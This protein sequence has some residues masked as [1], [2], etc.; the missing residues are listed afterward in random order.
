VV[1]PALDLSWGG[2]VLT[3]INNLGIDTV[4]LCSCCL[5]KQRNTSPDGTVFISV[6]LLSNATLHENV[7]FSISHLHFRSC[8]FLLNC[9]R[10]AVKHAL[11][12]LKMIATSGFLTALECT[13]FDF[14]RGSAPYPA[15]ELTLEALR[16]A[17][18]KFS[19]YLLTYSAPPAD[20]VAGLRGPASKER[21][22]RGT[23][24]KGGE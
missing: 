7:T 9:D 12:I 17:L 10:S 13:E 2:G 18:Y 16:N 6:L 3:L 5:V 11:K 22:G 20:P 8:P 24:G 23:G 1:S 4:S 14:G 15:G 19:T 21:R